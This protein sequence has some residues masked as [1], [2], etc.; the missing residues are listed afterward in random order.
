[1]PACFAVLRY[2]CADPRDRA[3][4]AACLAT[5]VEAVEVD[6]ALEWRIDGERASDLRAVLNT[7]LRSLIAADEVLHRPPRS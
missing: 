1:V 4:F 6:G 3:A 5:E 7:S 2:R